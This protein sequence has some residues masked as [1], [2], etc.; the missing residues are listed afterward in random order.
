MTGGGR[1][2][3]EIGA[4]PSTLYGVFEPSIVVDQVGVFKTHAKH[5]D[6]IFL[7]VYC[8][9]LDPVCEV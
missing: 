4:F 6:F 3:H 8:M 9:F 7:N 2:F 5:T 1:L